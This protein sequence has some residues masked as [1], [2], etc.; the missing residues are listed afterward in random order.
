[1]STPTSGA[2]EQYMAVLANRVDG[3]LDSG[4]DAWMASR[5]AEDTGLMSE[6]PRTRTHLA[7]RRSNFRANQANVASHPGRIRGQTEY[8]P[9]RLP[10][11]PGLPTWRFKR[12]RVTSCRNSLLCCPSV[13]AR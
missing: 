1:M 6:E 7:K 2:F 8:R 13:Q 10:S 11:P 12:T 5:L 9:R 3:G 4:R